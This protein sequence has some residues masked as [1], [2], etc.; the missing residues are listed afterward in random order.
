VVLVVDDDDASR[1]AAVAFLESLG[2]RAVS[3]A[4]GRQAFEVMRAGVRPS[5]ILLD[6]VMPEMDGWAF[7]AE[8]RKDGELA[9]IPVIVYSAGSDPRADLESLEAAAV[10]LKPADGER[11]GELVA[12]Y[13]PRGVGQ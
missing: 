5:L 12:R 4:N 9:G 2:Y 7:R 8:Q 3:A 6:L 10:L 13:C 11:L 1:E